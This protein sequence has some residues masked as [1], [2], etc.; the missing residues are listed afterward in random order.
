MRIVVTGAAGF[1]DRMVVQELAAR[2]VIVLDGEERRVSAIRFP[3]ISVRPGKPNRAASS[4]ASGIIREPL[5][6]ETAELPVGRDLRLHLASPRK[7]LDY[8]LAAAA[9][10]QGAIGPETTLTLPGISA[11]VGE[12]IDTLARVAGPE[13]AARIKPAPDPGMEAI[14]ASW[15]GAIR[16]PRAEAL[17]FVPNADFAEIVLEHMAQRATVDA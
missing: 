5:A 6:G 17:G 3:T 13:T 8:T 9:L 16:C 7:A 4:F 14:V 2:D 1:I 15:P 12:M 10:P 11:T